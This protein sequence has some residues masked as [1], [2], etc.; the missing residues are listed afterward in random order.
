MSGV[1]ALASYAA[2]TM[3]EGTWA[4]RRKSPGAASERSSASFLGSTDISVAG[5]IAG[6]VDD[7]IGEAKLTRKSTFGR[8]DDT[9][10]GTTCI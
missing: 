3:E 6:K 10:S 8:I 1:K 2:N 7:C 4:G 5:V 9:R